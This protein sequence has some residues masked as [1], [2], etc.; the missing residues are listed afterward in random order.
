MT[1]LKRAQII[2]YMDHSSTCE[3][4]ITSV[5]R[6]K[7]TI[8]LPKCKCVLVSLSKHMVESNIQHNISQILE[9]LTLLQPKPIAGTFFLI[10]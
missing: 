2:F 10:L 1:S 5:I 8:L 3:I 7:L 6:R 4:L 9:I